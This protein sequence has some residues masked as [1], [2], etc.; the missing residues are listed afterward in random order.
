MARARDPEGRIEYIV[1]DLSKPLPGYEGR[2]RPDDDKVDL[3]FAAE[4]EQSLTVL[5]PDG[6]TMAQL[7]DSGISRRCVQL[8]AVL[9]LGQLPGECM[10][11]PARPHDQ[12]FHASSVSKGSYARILFS[13]SNLVSIATSGR[14]NG[15]ASSR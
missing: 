8:V 6:M 1:H 13:W 3:V 12:N 4:R 5:G 9:A 10:L 7:G 2:F 11:A 14:P 15:K